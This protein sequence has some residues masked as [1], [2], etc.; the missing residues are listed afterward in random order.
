MIAITLIVI[1]IAII[2]LTILHVGD[3]YCNEFG[4][5][6]SIMDYFKSYNY[7]KKTGGR[8][9]D[10]CKWSSDCG[11]CASNPSIVEYEYTSNATRPG[12]I[13]REEKFAR[14]R[15]KNEKQ[16]CIEF[17]LRKG[18]DFTARPKIRPREWRI[19]K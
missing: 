2:I 13:L 11:Y 4:S 18:L 5:I 7:V 19:Y 14:C 8:Y 16:D 6:Y 9:C 1:L 15:T 17:Q 12:Y 10:Y 3:N